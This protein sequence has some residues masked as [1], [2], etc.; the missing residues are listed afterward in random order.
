MRRVVAVG[1]VAAALV[2]FGGCASGQGESVVSETPTQ[3][4]SA[5]TQVVPTS[6]SLPIPILSKQAD[7]YEVEVPEGWEIVRS[8]RPGVANF[9]ARKLGGQIPAT[10]VDLEHWGED[11][12]L[13]RYGGEQSGIFKLSR[14]DVL[15]HYLSF[16]SDPRFT[17]LTLLPEREIGGERA[18]GLSVRTPAPRSPV[19]KI[20][21]EE[22]Q[23]EQWYVV[24]HDGVWRF[25]ISSGQFEDEDD[26]AARS[27][28]D[29]FRWVGSGEPEPTASE[30]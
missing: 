15:E 6:S 30:S 10:S 28:L 4:A 11:W 19:G 13:E 7:S 25:V 8:S 1:A 2:L 22:L 18:V 29:S 9:S 27:I 17:D 14:E 21:G 26:V 3:G 16:Y 24:R 12:A 23:W 20:L 5:P